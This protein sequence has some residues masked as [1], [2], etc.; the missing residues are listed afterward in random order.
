[1][2]VDSKGNLYPVISSLALPGILVIDPAGRKLAFI[3]TEPTNQS[4]LFDDWKGIPSDV[5]FGTGD[6]RNVLY[7][8]IDKG[9]CRI[10][11]KSQGPNPHSGR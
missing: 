7:F 9:L 2:S 1:M 11:L 6:E 4:G 10:R 5:E 8:T 3:P